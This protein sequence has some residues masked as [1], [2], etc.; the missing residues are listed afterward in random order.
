MLD[1]R[2]LLVSAGATAAI[3]ALPGCR[4]DERTGPVERGPAELVTVDAGTILGPYAR[5]SG[6]QGSPHPIVSDD[7]DHTAQFR[8]YAI[9][10]VR[11]DQDCEPN[12]LTLG[13]TFPDERADPDLAASYSF[14][15]IDRHL[16]AARAAGASVLWQSSYDVG[17]SDHWDAVNLAGRPPR[18]LER[19]SRVV[20]RCL[21]HFNTGWAGGLDR[22]VAHVEFLNEP[23]GLGG[24]HGDDAPRLLP[25]FER[26]LDT[27]SAFA[28]DH[29]EAAAIAVGPGIPLSWAEWPEWEPRFD[30]ALE[31][32]RTAGRSL[33]VFSFH[34][35]GAD[36]S[37]VGNARLALALRALLDRHGM[38]ATALWNTEWQAADYLERHLGVDRA[39]IHNPTDDQR[40]AW[41]HAVATYALAC[42]VRWQGVVTGSYYYRATK[43]AFPPGFRAPA[44]DPQS[45]SGFF[46]PQGRVGSLA[47][48]ERL[49]QRIAHELP[50]RCAT[51]YDDDEQLAVL[52][53]CSSDR[54]AIG[55]LLCNL[56]TRTRRIDLGLRGGAAPTTQ[57]TLTRIDVDA[58]RLVE[59]GLAV[60]ARAAQLQHTNVTLPPL[61]SALVITRATT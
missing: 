17:R 5:L 53:L 56:S 8:E 3:F 32:I 1:R 61:T 36:T 27:V 6:V 12:S 34:T 43:R 33:P 38:H 50:Q 11:I 31:A 51:T 60:E 29:P 20:R 15:V 14:D 45:R 48:Q 37:P 40:I 21:E 2:Q 19:W 23:N 4:R 35:Y 49:T 25:V 16:R 26:F 44:V 30:R 46:S 28:H 58:A 18:D 55:A 22:A 42:K 59:S 9:E 47:L 10:H 13:G 24:F 57:G 39:R 7:I 41:A 54:S 52:G